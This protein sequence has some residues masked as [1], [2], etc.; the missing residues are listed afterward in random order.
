[1][2]QRLK[3]INSPKEINSKELRILILIGSFVGF[4]FLRDLLSIPIP[5]YILIGIALIIFIIGNISTMLAFL[6]FL[7]PFTTGIPGSFIIMGALI[8]YI[9]KT[10]RFTLNYAILSVWIIGLI[11]LF[12]MFET[13]NSLS[14]YI[15]IIIFIL[16]LALV[17]TDS[18]EK[19]NHYKIIKYYIYGYIWACIDIIFQ[20]LKEF[21][22][23]QFINSGIRFGR[24]LNYVDFSLEGK[25]VSPNVNSLGIYSVMVIVFIIVLISL[26]KRNIKFI[27]FA[28]FAGVIGSLTLSR[29]FMVSVGISL[30]LFFIFS[31]IMKKNIWKNA[32]VILGF[33]SI[34][35]TIL[36]KLMPSAFESMIAR[37]QVEDVT[38]GRVDISAYY[39]N[40]IL[41]HPKAMVMGVGLQDYKTKTNYFMS[42]HNGTQ[43]IIIAWGI[44]GMIC[45]IV[46]FWNIYKNAIRD[47][48]IKNSNPYL[49]SLLPALIFIFS[50][51]AS[52]LFSAGFL[53]ILIIPCFSIIRLS[54][55]HTHNNKGG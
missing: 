36:M 22:I 16:F 44:I 52:R 24:T 46:L 35:I 12:N 55:I 29:T 30:L 27:P 32:L 11:E 21:S 9:I 39:N 15:R 33:F 51:Q 34:F 41:T 40:Y 45:V 49:L 19:Y 47:S 4:I 43:E 5:T 8:I 48:L 25:L 10:K 42:A 26:E 7:V 31:I 1:M 6:A 54:V 14:L 37:F 50:L 2:K 13:N 3:V 20:T 28:L 23:S 53:M 17:L 18:T 38:S